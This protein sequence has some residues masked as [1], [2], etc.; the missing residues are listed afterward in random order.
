MENNAEHQLWY[1]LILNPSN[2]TL[3]E[4]NLALDDRLLGKMIRDGTIPRDILTH[5]LML[6]EKEVDLT[7]PLGQLLSSTHRPVCAYSSRNQKYIQTPLWVAWLMAREKQGGPEAAV[8]AIELLHEFGVVPWAD[9]VFEQTGDDCRGIDVLFH[10]SWAKK[11]NPYDSKAKHREK[12]LT[13]ALDKLSEDQL[14]ELRNRTHPN[15]HLVPWTASCKLARD[16]VQFDV[17]A[18]YGLWF[19]KTPPGQ[20]NDAVNYFKSQE[21]LTKA[22]DMGA[23]YHALR[24]RVCKL[25]G[26]LL[27]DKIA[28]LEK[29]DEKYAAQGNRTAMDKIINTLAAGGSSIHADTLIRQIEKG[30]FCHRAGFG[31]GYTLLNV[32][33]QAN[34]E[35]GS[36]V[37]NVKLRGEHAKNWEDFLAG[38]A[39]GLEGTGITEEECLAVAWILSANGN[40]DECKDFLTPKLLGR[41]L[42]KMS[43]QELMEIDWTQ[44]VR[45]LQNTQLW[46]DWANDPEADPN[47]LARELI[48]IHNNYTNEFRLFAAPIEEVPLASFR[49]Y[50]PEM[51]SMF[52]LYLGTF[53]AAQE[54]G[55]IEARDRWAERLMD[56]WGA[57]IVETALSRDS[58]NENNLDTPPGYGLADIISDFDPLKLIKEVPDCQVIKR[59]LTQV[60]DFLAQERKPPTGV[61]YDLVYENLL[62]QGKEKVK[63]IEYMTDHYPKTQGKYNCAVTASN[64]L[65]RIYLQGEYLREDDPSLGQPRVKM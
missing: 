4:N 39:K 61:G 31:L 22:M 46:N 8:K 10:M 11:I 7:G 35:A 5:K 54:K 12:I 52:H 33:S 26:L 23:P 58:E 59:K 3:I 19:S 40:Y 6:S 34:K 27:V 36:L 49:T 53:R 63:I 30:N 21:L 17:L 32:S 18:K 50:F 48:H 2:S 47:S 62:K 9:P 42:D 16:P 56:T 55:D 37:L 20:A 38:E 57:L 43:K 24:N 28:F 41:A 14:I 15:L 1:D 13:V 51:I 45:Q 64:L 25:G 65:K 29:I 44:L 60:C